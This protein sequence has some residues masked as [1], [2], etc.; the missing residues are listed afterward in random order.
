MLFRSQT[1]AP[2][3]ATP[4]A[5]ASAEPV[6]RLAV[7]I[8]AFRDVNGARRVQE[9]LQRAGFADARLVRVPGNELV[10]VRVGKFANRSAAASVLARLAAGDFSAVLVTDAT[11]EQPVR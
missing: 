4:T 8:G 5:T 7:Q 9:Q 11:E 3:A 2:A 6:A 1:P 10:R